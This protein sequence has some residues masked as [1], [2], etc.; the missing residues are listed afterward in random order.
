[1]GKHNP[2]GQ[3][4]IEQQ[5]QQVYCFIRDSEFFLVMLQYTRVSR[6]N[7]KFTQRFKFNDSTWK[8]KHLNI[9]EQK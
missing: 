5:F 4:L 8:S 6:Q 3:I 7:E 2:H 1:M 9:N